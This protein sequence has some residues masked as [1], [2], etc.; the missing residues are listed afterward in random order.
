MELGS[1][2]KKIYRGN[3]STGSYYEPVLKGLAMGPPT[4][5]A[6]PNPFVPVGNTNQDKRPR[7]NRDG[8]RPAASPLEPVLM[9]P[10]VSVC[11]K[12]VQNGAHHCAVF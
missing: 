8:S 5:A 9:P 1:G 12:P 4:A 3:F 7:T 6:S 2:W 10:L 11:V